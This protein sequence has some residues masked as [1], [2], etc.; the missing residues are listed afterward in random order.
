MQTKRL[1][2]ILPSSNTVVEPTCIAVCDGLTDISLHFARFKLTAVTVENPTAAYYD[3]GVILEAAMLL[4]DAR[5]D[6]ITWNGS[7][8]GLVGFPHDR[9]L[10]EDIEH[11]SGI[12]ATT[13]SLSIIDA[14]RARR[15]RRFAMV[16]LNP[17]AMNDT[18]KGHFAREGF[19]CVFDTHRADIPDNFAMAMVAPDEIFNAGLTCAE[20]KPDALIIYGT[21]TRGAPVVARLEERLGIPVFDSVSTGLWGAMQRASTSSADSRKWGSLF[22]DTPPRTNS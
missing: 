9:Q 13:A 15:V 7:A 6:V 5:C 18:I 11:A 22:N 16:T 14:L 20:A 4:A 3:S 21:N 10:V 2:I 17:P 12:A 19:E 1:G 8:G